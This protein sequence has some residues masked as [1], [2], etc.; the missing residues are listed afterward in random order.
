MLKFSPVKQI[1]ATIKLA[2]C[3]TSLALHFLR[4]GGGGGG[5]SRIARTCMHEKYI[6]YNAAKSVR[7]CVHIYT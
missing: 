1:E 5:M 6:M 2:L 7:M 4:G 3:S